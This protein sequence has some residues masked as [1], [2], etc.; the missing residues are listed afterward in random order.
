MIRQVNRVLYRTLFRL[1][2]S[3]KTKIYLVVTG[4]NHPHSKAYDR[5]C[6][7]VDGHHVDLK[8]H[9]PQSKK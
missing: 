1:F 6:P 3:L 7:T 5:K 2:P 9:F 8:K 4:Q